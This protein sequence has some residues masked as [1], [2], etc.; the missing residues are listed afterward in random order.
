MLVWF[1]YKTWAFFHEQFG[2]VP[3]LEMVPGLERKKH[4]TIDLVRRMIE[5]E[6]LWSERCNGPPY[7]SG[8]LEAARGEVEVREQ[9]TPWWRLGVRGA[10]QEVQVQ[11]VQVQEVQ[12]QD[13]QM[14]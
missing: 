2:S 6:P 11:Q 12:A 4:G 7:S 1:S 3:D 9:S 13:V 5:V 14:H 8:H 10:V